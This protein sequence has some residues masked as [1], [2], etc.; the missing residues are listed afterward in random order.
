MSLTEIQWCTAE[1]Q[2]ALDLRHRVLRAPLKQKFTA[3][4]L[5][6]EFQCRH[7]AWRNEDQIVA[8]V[9]ADT[10]PSGGVRLRQLVVEPDLEHDE[11]A[12]LLL[13]AVEQELASAG[14]KELILH[15]RTELVAAY[16]AAGFSIE[17][18][19]FHELGLSHT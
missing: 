5:D 9:V 15:A 10:L 8:A 14:V 16:Q 3:E 4:E 17:G 11:L 18:D 2:S 7:F 12:T 13:A 1:Y 6:V 19:P